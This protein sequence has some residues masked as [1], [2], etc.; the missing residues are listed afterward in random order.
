M[1]N[2]YK[3]MFNDFLNKQLD[4]SN[5]Q[6]ADEWQMF[7]VDYKKWMNPEIIIKLK[8]LS[9][10]PEKAYVFK[11]PPN[12]IQ[13][14]HI[15]GYE[16]VKRPWAINVAWGSENYSMKWFKIINNS[17]SSKYTQVMAPYL[18]FNKEDVEEIDKISNMSAPTLVRTDIPHSVENYDSKFRYCFTLRCRSSF[19][20][21]NNIVKHLDS[22]IEKDCL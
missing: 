7:N 11:G 19:K 15:D 21:W 18:M 17:S 12:F 2:Y 5:M 14:I 16:N 6:D 20:E 8:M 1:K 13:P 9:I 10:V 3:L 22:F 4:T